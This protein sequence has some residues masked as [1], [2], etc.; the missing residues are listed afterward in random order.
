MFREIA[1][2]SEPAAGS[3]IRAGASGLLAMA[4]A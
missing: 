2:I 3:L 4:A 1:R